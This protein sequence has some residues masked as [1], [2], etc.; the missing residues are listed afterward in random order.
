[1]E[2]TGV[3]ELCRKIAED[4]RN[5]AEEILRKAEEKASVRLDEARKTADRA[6]AEILES[7]KRDTELEIKRAVS[8]AQLESKRIELRGRETLIAEVVRQVGER[9]AQLRKTAGYADILKRLI[10]DGVEHIE[11]KELDILVSK[12]E[13]GI[14][15]PALMGR[16]ED[17]LVR[18]GIS[19]SKLAIS[20]I[21]ISETGVVVRSRTGKVEIRNTLE[22]R[23]RRM[24]RELRQLIS[25]EVFGYAN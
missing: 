15:T 17:E 3:Q 10:L 6:A 4:S 12:D 7:V 24:N 2:D 19:G 25:K 13:R 23:I 16:I 14:L 21:P 20:E 5:Q 11:E 22:S 9:I 8:K 18:R 1:M